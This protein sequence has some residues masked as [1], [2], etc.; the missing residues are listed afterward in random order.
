[1]N[2]STC[3][4]L[5]RHI[6]NVE[7]WKRKAGKAEYERFLKGEKLTRAEAIRAHCY[8]CTQGEDTEPCCVLCCPLR[9]F[10][11]WGSGIDDD[12]RHT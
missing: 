6:K 2:A 4:R 11:Q 1:M 3:D 8:Q 5:K 9:P 12:P 7:K 10:S